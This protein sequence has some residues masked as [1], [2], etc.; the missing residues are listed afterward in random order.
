MYSR[1]ACTRRCGTAL[2]SQPRSACARKVGHRPMPDRSPSLEAH[3][4]TLCF[5][6]H[7]RCSTDQ[8]DLT[9]HRRGPHRLPGK[10]Q[11]QRSSP[12]VGP[13]PTSP[14]CLADRRPSAAIQEPTV[15]TDVTPDMAVHDHETFGPVN[16]GLP[17]PRGPL[18]PHHLASPRCPPHHPQTTKRGWWPGGGGASD[19]GARVC[20]VHPGPGSVERELVAARRMPRRAARDTPLVCAW[21]QRFPAR[22]WR[23]PDHPQSSHVRDIGGVGPLRC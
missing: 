11:E 4:G 23:P 14:R 7:A 21:V 3:H 1:T 18:A 9:A 6:G 17:R 13:V 5:V 10:P 15:V 22:P 12:A 16:V 20:H 19:C 8:R 2:G